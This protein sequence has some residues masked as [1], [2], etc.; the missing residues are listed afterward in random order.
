MKGSQK[1]KLGSG[2]ALILEAAEQVGSDGRG[3]DGLVGYLRML[4][5]NYPRQ[6]IALLG[7]IVDYE[8]P[9]ETTTVLRTREEIE[10]E[11]RARGLSVPKESFS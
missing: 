6:F 4:A 8:P 7:K 9:R 5:K 10:A 1:N 11:M 2:A 3:R